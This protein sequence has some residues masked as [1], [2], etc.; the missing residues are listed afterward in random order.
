MHRRAGL[1][2]AGAAIFYSGTGALLAAA[3]LDSASPVVNLTL[4][5]AFLRHGAAAPPPTSVRAPRAGSS[6]PRAG[7]LGERRGGR[8]RIMEEEARWP[9]GNGVDWGSRG[10]QRLQLGDWKEELSSAAGRQS[11]SCRGTRR[12]H[13]LLRHEQ[14]L[15]DQ[16]AP[17]A[18]SAT[19]S[20]ARVASEP[21]SGRRPC[22]R[23][24]A[25]RL[26]R[27]VPPAA[28]PGVS[29]LRRRPAHHGT[30]RH[31]ASATALP[32]KLPPC[33]CLR[34]M[35]EGEADRQERRKKKKKK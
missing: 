7:L 10:G 35:R 6:V 25:S 19:R 22:R 13:L 30:Q 12:A 8:R 32:P 17:S 11:G 24:L 29:R 28:A 20:H 16:P 31:P 5:P 26:T 34:S 33:P 4:R 27:S 18:S 14:G 1:L 3:G 9:Y 23:R 15:V 2:H 21:A